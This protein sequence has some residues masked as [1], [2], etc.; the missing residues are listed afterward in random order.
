VNLNNISNKEDIKV[1]GLIESEEIEQ[2]SKNIHKKHLSQT[3][4][5]DNKSA[6][7]KNAENNKTKNDTL[8]EVNKT[9]KNKENIVKIQ[10]PI[11]KDISQKNI[12]FKDSANL[13]S[14]VAN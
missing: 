2:I 12:F 11:N 4:A 6:E 3:K 10:D 5:E 14:L 7:N 1:F 13:Y 9:N 8:K